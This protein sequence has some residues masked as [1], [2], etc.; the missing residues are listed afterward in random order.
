MPLPELFE[1]H[2]RPNIFL[3]ESRTGKFFHPNCGKYDCEYCSWKKIKIFSEKV[4]HFFQ[5]CRVR[6]LTLTATNRFNQFLPDH[7][8]VLAW[9][10]LIRNL[11]NRPAY[12]SLKKLK[13]IRIVEYQKNGN[14]HYH[15]LVD[16]Y[17]HKDVIN[18]L[19]RKACSEVLE[20]Y[21]L[22][23]GNIERFANAN[24]K[25]VIDS[26]QVAQ[27]IKKYL[28]KSVR[29]DGFKDRKTYRYRPYSV[30][31]NIKF[32]HVEKTDTG[33]WRTF[34]QRDLP[35]GKSLYL[36]SSC[37]LP[38]IAGEKFELVVSPELYSILL[39]ET[40]DYGL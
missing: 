7:L 10:E 37:L 26:P 15:V 2:S 24:I 31:R 21:G 3:V 25:A 16:K 23:S 36:F 11:R 22:P 14:T 8:P 13:Y 33:V 12:S 39:G 9:R 32:P 27:Y 19:W 1:C 30:S 28:T 18:H 29:T 34:T 38:K 17:I 5:N 4:G 40:F 20:K 35:K 6:F